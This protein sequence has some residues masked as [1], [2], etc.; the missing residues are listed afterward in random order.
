M[1]VVQF[2]YF[3]EC[4]EL[5]FFAVFLLFLLFITI[6]NKIAIAIGARKLYDFNCYLENSR[7]DC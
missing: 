2:D 4:A 3:M 6:I 7:L 1:V 5:L